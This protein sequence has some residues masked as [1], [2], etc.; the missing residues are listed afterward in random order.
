[1]FRAFRM[2]LHFGKCRSISAAP[3]SGWASMRAI[4]RARKKSTVEDAKM[5]GRYLKFQFR[6]LS[7]PAA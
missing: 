1:M 3:H 7:N 6:F 4:A 5:S 2:D